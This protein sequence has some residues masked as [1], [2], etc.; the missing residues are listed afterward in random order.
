[1][2]NETEA[3]TLGEAL[4]YAA[5]GWHVFPVVKKRPIVK[6]GTEA[7]TDPEQ[8]VA[9]FAGARPEVGVAVAT[10]PSGLLVVDFDSHELVARYGRM[11]RPTL[12]ASTRRGAHYYY[13]DPSGGGRNSAGLLAVGVDT[14]GRGGFVVAPPSRGYS[15]AHDVDVA[16]VPRAILARLARK[17]AQLRPKVWAPDASSSQNLA[18]N[19]GGVRA[20]REGKRNDALNRAAFN[21]RAL[22]LPI[23]VAA[24]ELVRAGLD[25][26]LPLDEVAATVASGL[27]TDVESVL[28]AIS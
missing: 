16:E 22:G 3:S 9:W 26:G 12:V 2:T 25:V 13:S 23:S 24:P 21:T 5:R 28:G 6:W 1:M 8:V 10:G 11:M 7:T 20:A 18:I 17:P 27:G 4:R 19:A 15:W 14:R